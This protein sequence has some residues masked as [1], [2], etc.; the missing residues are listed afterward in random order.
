M[1]EEKLRH[2]PRYSQ[3]GDYMPNFLSTIEVSRQAMVAPHRLVY[4]LTQ[5][6]IREPKRLNGR[7][8]FRE[9]DVEIVKEY[10]SKG[11][12]YKESRKNPSRRTE[13]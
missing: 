10:F 13:S 12:I 6:K 3:E 11:N 7:R 1:T 5:N 8:L 9:K 2:E 4:A